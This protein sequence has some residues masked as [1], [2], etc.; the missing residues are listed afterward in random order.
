MAGSLSVR[1]TLVLGLGTTGKEVAEQLAEHLNWQFGSFEN[2]AWVRLLVLETEQPTSFLGDRVLRGGMTSAEYM[3]YITHPNTAGA[4]FDFYAWQDGPTLGAINDPSTGAGNLRMLGRLCLFHPRTYNNLKMRLTRDVAYLNSLDPHTIAERLGQTGL[5]VS[6]HSDTV[7]YVVGTLCG[8]TCSGAAAD[9]G[10]LIDSWTDRAV[11]RQAIFT[12]P[13]PALTRA[14]APRYKKNAYYALKE[15]NHYQLADHPWRQMLPGFA[16][17]TENPRIPYDILRIVMPGGPSGED[18]T[19]L[20]VTIGQYL[21]A[22]VGP[23]GFEI[24]ANDVNALSKM[25]STESIGFIRPLFST[26]GVAA[27][28]YP[29]EHIL[30]AATSRLL[31]G[32]Y[33]RWTRR[34]ADSELSDSAGRL[35]PGDLDAYLL[36]LTRGSEQFTA[37]LLEPMQRGPQ[38]GSPPR[39]D[40]LRQ[41]LRQVNSQLEADRAPE[42]DSAA[43][44]GGAMPLSTLLQRM[45]ENQAQLLESLQRELIAFVDR[46]LFTLEGGPGFVI[47]SLRRVLHNV[48]DWEK[49]AQETLP[50]QR[51][52]A[53]ALRD[54][55]EA[56]ITEAER[57]QSSP[58]V[59][60][61]DEKL[62]AAWEEAH[63]QTRSYLE[64]ETHAQAITHIQRRAMVGAVAAQYRKVTALLQRRLEQMESAFTQ[65]SGA[66][67]EQWKRMAARTPTV[68]GRV[69][70]DPEPPAPQGTLSQEYFNLLRQIRWPGEPE[71]G[72][73]DAGKETAAMESVLAELRPLREELLREEGSGAF[74]PRPGSATARETIP[75]ATLRAAEARARDCFSRLRTQAH[76]ADKA[77]D[78]DCDTVI[79]ASE[80]RLSVSATQVSDQLPGTRGA[81]PMPTNLAFMDLEGGG[82]L[83][84]ALQ[85]VA[86]RVQNSLPLQRNRITPSDDPFR[87]LIIREKHGFT[88][89]QMSGVVRA[90]PHDLHALQSAEH[91]DDF[92]F[93]H[94][95]RDVDWVDPLVPP[96]H[97]ET[98]AEAW[99]LVVLLGHP[100]DQA[101]PWLPASRGEIEPAGWYQLAAGEFRVFY[102]PGMPDVSEREAQLPRSFQAATAR[103]MNPA[104]AVLRR[105]L[106]NRFSAYC[107]SAPAPAGVSRAVSTAT[108][109]LE[110]LD[111]FGL[112]DLT[113]AAAD[114]ILRRAFR[115]N[116]SLTRAFFDLRTQD[117][118]RQQ[119]EFAHLYHMQGDPIAGKNTVYAANG[120]YCPVCN[121]FLGGTIQA[122]L[123]GMFYCPA[124]N[125]GQRYWP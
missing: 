43:P 100:A 91:C 31:A 95:R 29:G 107:A 99:L 28:E 125:S 115:R 24:A 3:P 5:N 78:A 113:R 6:I 118:A 86:D 81:E 38:S 8:G 45:Q 63:A 77:T 41:L 58:F 36:Q 1:K 123:D 68:N 83:R 22:A 110:S 87:L 59:F 70:F 90:G 121:L 33:S 108:R 116:D 2:A 11:Q 25:A 14:E 50:E 94:T 19:R 51:R 67:E 9:L 55:L 85:R 112:T 74:D 89:G 42:P 79:L 120:Y 35:L 7:V 57:I 20:N 10:Y 26:L 98:A 60:R 49:Q 101:L 102:P 92:R 39:A 13:H 119:A 48:E 97:V 80:P 84:P 73:D 109:A 71:T 40:H 62:W 30:R 104:F 114:T 66:L 72:W 18:V 111:I 34:R 56:K 37:P 124:C 117:L 76:I 46:T 4:E 64:R 105:T 75:G 88:L 16:V 103:L 53:D 47:E 69:Y 106:S 32:T 27:L 82:T 17:P 93:W 12:L 52:D 15:L 65:E 61:K 122:L 23:A 21:A 44:A 96:A 54:M